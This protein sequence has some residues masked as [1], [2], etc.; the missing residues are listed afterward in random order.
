MH[1]S[2]TASIHWLPRWPGRAWARS[3]LLTGLNTLVHETV[4]YESRAEAGVQLPALTLSRR[5]G[6]CRDVAWLLV[7]ALRHIGIGSRFVSG[8]L[9]QP[10]LDGGQLSAQA[11]ELHA[12]TE[13]YLPG[14]GWIGLDPTLG[15]LCNEEH[16]PL[17]ACAHYQ[18]A[19]PVTGSFL[20][21]DVELHHR[22]SVVLSAGQE[23]SGER[24]A[25]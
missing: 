2:T 1:L 10:Q 11:S 3:I 4:G 14:A 23:G 19:A 20:G 15:K 9:V 13:A 16:I 17:A 21:T 6:S 24:K 25:P 5:I 7:C 12:W 22:M 18:S 8:Y